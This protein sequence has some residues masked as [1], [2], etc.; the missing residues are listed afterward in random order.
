VVDSPE[1]KAPLQKQMLPMENEPLI[2]IVMAARNAADH[3]QEA[4]GSV[5]AQTWRNWELIVVDNASTDATAFLVQQYKDPR[6]RLLHQATKGVGHARNTALAIITGE[7]YCFLDADDELPPS[8][9]AD[10]ATLLLADPAVHFADGPTQAFNASTKNLWTRSPSYSGPA[11]LTEL[12][13]ISSR[14][15]VGVT[16]MIRRSDGLV[17][18]FRT[19]MTHAEDLLYFMSIAHAGAYRHT[20]K[21]VC[22]YRVGHVSAMS[23]LHGLHKGYRQ[24]VLAMPDLPVPPTNETLRLAWKKIRRILWK[25]YLKRGKIRSSIAVMLEGCPVRSDRK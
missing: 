18:L 24:L 11:P 16:W 5:Q 10:R 19:D 15:F 25:S 21:P 2:S 12:F 7:F 9:L 4:I 17:P 23:D 3:I 13:S 20:T 14:C 1:R 8:S 6:I 22:H